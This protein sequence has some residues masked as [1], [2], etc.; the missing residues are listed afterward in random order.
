MCCSEASHGFVA[1]EIKSATRC[2]KRF[3]HGLRLREHLPGTACYGVYF[4]AKQP[5]PTSHK[6]GA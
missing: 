3:N 1:I 4:P 2:D 5:P 6:I